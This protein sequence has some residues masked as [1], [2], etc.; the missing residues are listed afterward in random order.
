MPPSPSYAYVHARMRSHRFPHAHTLHKRL[1][2]QL[3]CSLKA[4]CLE[5]WGSGGGGG[6][7]TPGL[8]GTHGCGQAGAK[9]IATAG[10]EVRSSLLWVLG[11]LRL[12]AIG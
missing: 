11:L 12:P 5:A 2:Q 8:V 10:T 1:Q 4:S 6:G 9:G 3:T 7:V